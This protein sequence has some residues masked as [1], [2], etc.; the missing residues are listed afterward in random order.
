MSRSVARRAGFTLIE[1]LVVIAI[2]GVLVS[3]LLPA[4]QAAREAGR[5][6]QCTNHLKQIGLAL[7]NYHSVHDTLPP[8]RIRSRVDRLGLV[9]SVFAQIL[10]QL[11]QAPVFHAI[12]FRLNADRGVGFW[13]NDTA[14]RMR[15]AVYLCPSDTTSIVSDTEEQAPINYQM[16]VGTLHPVA[17]NTGLFFENSRVR[18]ASIRDG[19]S[20][21]AAM[22]ELARGE[23]FRTNWVIEVVNVPLTSYESTCTPNGPAVPRARGN[24]WI[25]AAPNHTMYSHHRVPND[26][27][28]DC[29]TGSPFGDQTNAVWDLLGIDGAARSFHPGGVNVLF[30]DGS[31]RF[32]KDSI[33]ANVWRAIGTRSGGEAVSADSL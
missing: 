30:A 4:V 24:R 14:R 3:L 9:Y 18:F 12:N 26:F 11:D 28:P 22:S 6:V 15:V 33:S 19:S 16:N 31:V 27:N 7:H 5:R 25:Y 10:P 20:L 17:N 32:V 8:G 1:L 21:T 29:R 13:E 2:I 23:G